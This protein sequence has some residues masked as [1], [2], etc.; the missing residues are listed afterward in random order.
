MGIAYLAS[1]ARLSPP[2]AAAA[3]AAYAVEELTGIF[4]RFAQQLMRNII[5][6]EAGALEIA[7]LIMRAVG[8]HLPSIFK[9]AV[10]NTLSQMLRDR[11]QLEI[12]K[13]CVMRQMEGDGWRQAQ[14]NYEHHVEDI[15]TAQG[16]LHPGLRQTYLSGQNS[17]RKAEALLDEARAMS[18]QSESL[19]RSVPKLEKAVRMMR[20]EQQGLSRGN[21]SPSWQQSKANLI[22]AAYGRISKK[23]NAKRG[24]K[25]SGGVAHQLQNVRFRA[26]VECRRTAK[27]AIGITRRGVRMTTKMFQGKAPSIADVVFGYQAMVWL[28]DKAQ[29]P[30][31]QRVAY[32]ERSRGEDTL[33]LKSV[34]TDPVTVGRP[35]GERRKYG[36][37]GR[38]DERHWDILPG[39]EDQ[40]SGLDGAPNQVSRPIADKAMD[41]LNRQPGMEDFK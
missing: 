11:S 15:A 31:Q 25:R 9:S 21:L 6:E 28:L 26:V 5:S 23:P 20:E 34:G 4:S 37:V 32:T 29:N 18:G 24:N 16:I 27:R 40:D 35:A 30:T 10:K 2:V 33:E 19:D 17:L 14:A 38:G 7:T 1:L 36:M 13:A 22:E 12:A 3:V 39:V 8:G 41:I